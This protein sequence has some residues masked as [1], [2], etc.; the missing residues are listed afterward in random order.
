MLDVWDCR[1]INALKELFSTLR[2]EFNKKGVELEDN[3]K[4]RLDFVCSLKSFDE[5]YEKLNLSYFVE[6]TG[7]IAQF[8]DNNFDC[9]FSFHVLEHVPKKYTEGLVENIYRSLKPGGY[10]IHQIGIDDHL[11]HYDASESPKKY[12]CY[13]DAVWKIFFENNIQYFNRMQ[14]SEWIDLF[15]QRGLKFI[16][17]I[18]YYC[19]I[20]D[21]NVHPRF[22]KY[23]DE[24]LRCTTLTIIHQKPC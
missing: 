20:S 3:A 11:T 24:D 6:E 5:L 15:E 7:S 18:P 2:T 21:I 12:I 19:D 14:M 10:S 22:Q 1:Q 4:E 13:S 8:P 23:P 17:K 9:V 16:D